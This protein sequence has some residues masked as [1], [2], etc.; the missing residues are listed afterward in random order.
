MKHWEKF[1]LF[2]EALCRK[3]LSCENMHNVEVHRMSS[4]MQGGRDVVACYVDHK[5]HR[6]NIYIECKYYR[7]RTINSSELSQK[8]GQVKN[9]FVLPQHW[10]LLAPEY[11]LDNEAEETINRLRYKEFLDFDIHRWDSGEHVK[12]VKQIFDSCRDQD[13]IGTILNSTEIWNNHAD[14]LKLFSDALV[15]LKPHRK[16]QSGS[17]TFLTHGLSQSGD[18][19]PEY[20]F[21]GQP[22]SWRL[23]SAP[24]D[25]RVDIPRTAASLLKELITQHN[26]SSSMPRLILKV[27]TGLYGNG[28]TTLLRRLA[29]DLFHDGYA[30]WYLDRTTDDEAHEIHDFMMRTVPLIGD[31]SPV[32]I[33]DWLP[34]AE[35]CLQKIASALENQGMKAIGLA[36]GSDTDWG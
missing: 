7:S 12:A 24:D 1:E 10:V 13:D 32:I 16:L 14:A 8:A 18:T 5:G 34:G 31:R 11:P 25:E 35:K 27:V 4:G 33:V 20:F 21:H 26:S 17:I 23:L 29:Y 6:N 36:A 9:H 3:A 28:K 15:N 22:I 30:V 2:V 19:H